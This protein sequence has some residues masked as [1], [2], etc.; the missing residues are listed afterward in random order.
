MSVATRVPAIAPHSVAN[1][2]VAV[3]M[4]SLPSARHARAATSISN[5]P[6]LLVLRTK[7]KSTKSK[8][9]H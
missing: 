5:T 8:Q 2:A 4:V 1:V 6:P 7:Q 3:A 9:S